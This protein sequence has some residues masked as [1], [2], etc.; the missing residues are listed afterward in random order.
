MSSLDSLVN[1]LRQFGLEED[2]AEVY[3][4]MIKHEGCVL[5]SELSEYTSLD[6]KQVMQILRKLEIK[7]FVYLLSSDINLYE[8]RFPQ[9]ALNNRMTDILKKLQDIKQVILST[10]PKPPP[11]GIIARNIST[12]QVFLA[13]VYAL[14]NNANEEI[15]IFAKEITF[16]TDD[17]KK[18]LDKKG[19][20]NVKVLLTTES[21]AKDRAT[22][23]EKAA[24]LQALGVEIKLY[25]TS[26][27]LRYMTAD[28]DKVLFVEGPAKDFGVLRGHKAAILIE[29]RELTRYFKLNFDE[30]W[31]KKN[32]TDLEV[33]LKL[34]KTRQPSTEGVKSELQKLRK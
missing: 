25:S 7:N 20:L 9:D 24:E 17:F 3:A 27:E 26:S 2:E 11:P 16:S 1:L 15:K 23:L 22:T 34:L 18:I 31:K 32:A 14:L 21:N 28:E 6:E 4:M 33:V 5:P 13:M 10:I 12:P 19:G 8:V 29:S 30:D